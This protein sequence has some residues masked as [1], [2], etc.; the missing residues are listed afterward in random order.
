VKHT[1]GGGP[2]L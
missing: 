2:Y 1:R